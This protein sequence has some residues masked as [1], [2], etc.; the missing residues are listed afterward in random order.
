MFTNFFD[1]LK[2][3]LGEFL[4][5]DRHAGSKQLLRHLH[6]IARNMV[7]TWNMPVQNQD[8]LVQFMLEKK[9]LK[10][11][12]ELRELDLNHATASVL[13]SLRYVPHEYWRG[14]RRHQHDQAPTSLEEA[15]PEFEALEKFRDD[16]AMCKARDKV[17]ALY[18]QLSKPEQQTFYR[19]FLHHGQG[20]SV[21]K[22]GKAQGENPK[23][24]RSRERRLLKKLRQM[25]LEMEIK[26]K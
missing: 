10:R 23:T 26:W 20:F 4:F 8:D 17:E 24:L 1:L 2:L 11:E 7:F 13:A 19:M 18:A 16:E 25:L 9:I 12:A 3:A 21:E 22:L 14:E 6:Q 15:Q 5:G